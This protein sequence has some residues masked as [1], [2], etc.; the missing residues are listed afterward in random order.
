MIDASRDNITSP[1]W[2]MPSDQPWLL[3]DVLK[4]DDELYE[5]YPDR[6]DYIIEAKL[7]T[8]VLRERKRMV[9]VSILGPFSREEFFNYS[10]VRTHTEYGGHNLETAVARA[11]QFHP[12][13]NRL[14]YTVAV[15]TA[16]WTWRD[17]RYW[18]LEDEE[19]N[20]QGDQKSPYR[21]VYSSE[22]VGYKDAFAWTKPLF[23]ARSGIDRFQVARAAT[24]CRIPV[25]KSRRDMWNWM[26]THLHIQR[27]LKQLLSM[28]TL[29]LVVPG[30]HNQFAL[31]VLERDGQ[32]QPVCAIIAYSGWMK[33]SELLRISHVAVH[34]DW[35]NQLE[36]REAGTENWVFISINA[37]APSAQ[38]RCLFRRW[39]TLKEIDSSS[40]AHKKLRL[41]TT[42]EIEEPGDEC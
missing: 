22:I 20:S 34:Q 4:Q 10:Q 24:P 27:T 31:K 41:W 28:A 11:E 29:G 14:F 18:T 21:P 37:T 35:K 2:K 16:I 40:R 26:K 30:L 5:V 23:A 1:E 38:Q 7:H 8:E 15:L 12:L 17:R 39:T 33:A 42:H 25:D 32:Q 19:T 9:D 13:R 6:G 3:S 36:S